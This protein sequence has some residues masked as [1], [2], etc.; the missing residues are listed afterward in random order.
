MISVV[1]I[2]QPMLEGNEENVMTRGEYGDE[3]DMSSSHDIT[4]RA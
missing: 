2:K 3:D 4:N 1:K